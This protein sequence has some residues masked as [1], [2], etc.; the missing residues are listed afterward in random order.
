MVD[1]RE[2]C[3]GIKPNQNIPSVCQSSPSVNRSVDQRERCGGNKSNH[4]KLNQTKPDQTKSNHS[5]RRIPGTPVASW[6]LPG[7]MPRKAGCATRRYGT[8][9]LLLLSI[10]PCRRDRRRPFDLRRRHRLQTLVQEL[11]LNVNTAKQ[12]AIL[13]CEQVTTYSADNVVVDTVASFNSFPVL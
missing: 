3:G 13:L 10:A 7:S 1:Q 6:G 11:Q 12:L 2:R 8:S 4:P 5:S 9:C